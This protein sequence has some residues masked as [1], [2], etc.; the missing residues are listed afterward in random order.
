MPGRVLHEL[1]ALWCR[2]ER[3]DEY[4]GTLVNAWLAGGGHAVGVRAGEAYVDVG[5][6][7]GNREAIPL[8][9][10]TPLAL[11]EED[12]RKTEKENEHDRSTVVAG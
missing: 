3:R 11:S 5:T 10:E 9:H 1:Y 6:L 12:L 2:P 8:L 7:H 4:M